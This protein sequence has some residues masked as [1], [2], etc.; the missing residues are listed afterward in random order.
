MRI[1]S[2]SLSETPSG[3]GQRGWN[4]Q[5][6]TLALLAFAMLI[7]S[8]DQYLVVVA[9]PSIGREL[10]FSPQTLQWVISANAVTSAGFLL[11]GGRAADLLGRRR[12]FVTGLAVYGGASLAG[13]LAPTPEFLLGARAVQGLGGA[14]VFPAT[15]S[16]VNTTF[17]EGRERNR[18]LA[19]WGGAGAAGLVLGVLLGGVLTRALG[20]EAAFFVNVP[21]AGVA[22]LLAFPLIAADRGREAGRRFD[23]PGALSATLGVTLLVFA[24]VQGPSLGWGS[25]AVLASAAASLL[26]LA[27]FA[28]IELRSRE[29]LLPPRLL[30]NRNL[31][32]AVAIAFLFWATFG[33]VLYFL[34]LYF[35]D[36]RGYDALETGVGF[37]LPTVVVVAGSALAGPLATRFGLR[38]T[39]VAALAVGGLGA[40]ALGLA[41]SPD[42][43]YAALVPGLIALS[44]GDGVAFTTI[45]I[46]AG[47]GVS[48]REQ[49]VASGIAST[50]TSVGAAV[51]LAL[52]VIVANSGTDAL[53][54]E[55]LRIATAEGLSAAVLVIAAG[56]A[57]TALVALNLR[58]GPR[59]RAETPC[60]RRVAVSVG[61]GP[62]EP[63]RNAI[64][65][66]ERRARPREQSSPG[67]P[68]AGRVGD[69]P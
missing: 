7:T 58:P 9:L 1:S 17:A 48:D 33:S 19:V 24:L 56:I 4:R 20:W 40:L 14:L 62:A 49:G 59:T 52:L 34:T 11:L 65:T 53:A 38:P 54:G 15:L 42:A 39:L 35:Q 36:V 37:L 67:S 26:S 27:A 32:T 41:M 66:P 29:P 30:A 10:G 22:L 61:P 3:Q 57:V 47:T 45:F 68:E 8:L 64:G 63:D 44:I 6:A 46:A 5:A 60:P 69:D 23:L 18:A 51:G 12:I 21:L 50:S 2:A 13:G 25:P 55:A 16:L 43:S 28:L 31:G